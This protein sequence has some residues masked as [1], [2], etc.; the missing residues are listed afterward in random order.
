MKITE[1]QYKKKNPL[2]ADFYGLSYSVSAH[3]R[4]EEETY[5][6]RKEGEDAKQRDVK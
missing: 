6:W 4:V 5:F 1:S 2:E 3:F